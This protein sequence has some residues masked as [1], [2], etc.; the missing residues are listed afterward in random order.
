MA[1]AT[2]GTMLD[3]VALGIFLAAMI[4]LVVCGCIFTRKP[5]KSPENKETAPP[6]AA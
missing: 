3:K 6:P 1:W 5:R 2:E 4:A